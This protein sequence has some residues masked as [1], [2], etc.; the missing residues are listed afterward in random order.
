MCAVSGAVPGTG[1]KVDVDAVPQIAGQ[2]LLELDL[3]ANAE[4]PWRLPGMLLLWYN[5]H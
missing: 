2:S 3:E 5:E 4:K 1:K